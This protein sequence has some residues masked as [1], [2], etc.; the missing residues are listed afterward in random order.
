MIFKIMVIE[1]NDFRITSSDEGSPVWDLE[2]LYVI[3]PRKGESRKEFKNAGYG[4]LLE[5]CIKRIINFRISNKQG[6]K[7]MTMKQYLEM[8]RLENK[9][10]RDAIKPVN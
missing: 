1:E 2:L 4:M 9:L 10:I 7:A 3:K 6:E 5:S 8:Y